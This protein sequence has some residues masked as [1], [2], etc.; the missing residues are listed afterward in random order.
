MAAGDGC[1]CVRARACARCRCVRKAGDVSGREAPRTAAQ[2]SRRR[3]SR[4]APVAS[5]HPAPPRTTREKTPPV[6]GG[7]VKARA[8]A[9]AG[10]GTTATQGDLGDGRSPRVRGAAQHPTGRFLAR[11]PGCRAAALPRGHFRY[12]Q[13]RRPLALVCRGEQLPRLPLAPRRELLVQRRRRRV[14]LDSPRALLAPHRARLLAAAHRMRHAVGTH[15][16]LPPALAPPKPPAADQPRAPPRLL[17]HA[18]RERPEPLLAALP[19]R[20]AR[21][22]A[23][24]LRLRGTAI[25][26]HAARVG[27]WPQ[28]ERRE[29]RERHAIHLLPCSDRERHTLDLAAVRHRP[30]AD[31]A[32]APAPAAAL[33][34]LARAVALHPQPVV[35]ASVASAQAA[36]LAGRA[37]PADIAV[38]HAE[39]RVA[40]AAPVAVLRARAR[41]QPHARLHHR[42][43]RL[44]LLL[45]SHQRT[46]GLGKGGGGG[47]GG[48]E[49]ARAT[50][51][52]TKSVA[53]TGATSSSRTMVVGAG[54]SGPAEVA[55]RIVISDASLIDW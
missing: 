52:S 5:P 21:R 36:T 9:G 46:R 11:R 49:D 42:A 7:R 51:C 47:G 20:P 27:A 26:P 44:L 32:R 53:C 17:E 23:L 34:A 24:H 12:K 1:G 19:L 38:A 25:E 3:R 8:V 41:G 10:S 14:A 33:V 18:P 39:Q 35:R 30:H 16:H 45:C 43:R 4:T 29:D 50:G 48:S 28:F 13:V 55:I 15:L 54:V 6:G 40:H 2:P 22:A 37:V 31:L